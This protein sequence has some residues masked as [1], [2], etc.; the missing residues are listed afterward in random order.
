MPHHSILLFFF[1]KNVVPFENSIRLVETLK[2][3]NV[4][5][6]FEKFPSDV[7]G[8]GIATDTLADGW[9]DR[10]V[11]YYFSVFQ[12]KNIDQAGQ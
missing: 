3:N 1:K 10:M 11:E 12:N 5:F 2:N 6:R 9:V 8:W 4:N 7:H